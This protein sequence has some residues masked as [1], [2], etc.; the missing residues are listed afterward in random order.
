ME[1]PTSLFLVCFAAFVGYF[2][3]RVF[4]YGGLR[5]AL[6]GS[7]I[8]RTVGEL[9]LGRVSGATH[10]LRVHVL[11]NGKIVLELKSRTMLSASLHGYPMTTDNAGQLVALLQQARS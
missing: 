2:L 8:A 3:F 10:T 6:F 1:I 11:E 5:G 7:A 4:K 9:E